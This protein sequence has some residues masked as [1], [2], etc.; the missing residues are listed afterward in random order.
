MALI[1]RIAV[2]AMVIVCLSFAF[3][4]ETTMREKIYHEEEVHYV[5]IKDGHRWHCWTHMY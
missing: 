5:Y 2:M 3:C 4:E 1:K